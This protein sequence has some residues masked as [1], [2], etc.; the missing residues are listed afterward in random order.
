MHAGVYQGSSKPNRSSLVWPSRLL[1][2][3]HSGIGAALFREV[4]PALKLGH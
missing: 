2:L 1:C 3:D 4:H